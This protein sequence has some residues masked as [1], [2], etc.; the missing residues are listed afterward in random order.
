MRSKAVA[1][2]N[3]QATLAKIAIDDPDPSVRLAAVNRLN[4]QATLARIA[5]NDPDPLFR[6]AAFNRLNDH[7]MLAKIAIDAPDPSLR[8]AVLPRMHCDRGT[9]A[10]I[11]A[12]DPDPSLRSAA[13]DMLRAMAASSLIAELERALQPRRPGYENY[14]GD[15]AQRA[16]IGLGKCGHP[17]ALPVLLDFLARAKKAPDGE[18]GFCLGSATEAICTLAK[19]VNKHHP[20]KRMIQV[21]ERFYTC[22]SDDGY[23]RYYEIRAEIPWPFDCEPPAW[24]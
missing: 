4:D 9:L 14:I 13:E 18:R 22:T 10:K 3:D 17:S 8:L 7:A 1:R 23:A 5:I 24:R 16:A 12:D 20:S 19:G 21:Q 15:T 11:A 6:L 2:L